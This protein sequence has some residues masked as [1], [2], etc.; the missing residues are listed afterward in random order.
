M[1]FAISLFVL[2]ATFAPVQQQPPSVRTST[3]GVLIDVTANPLVK[4]RG[5][6]EVCRGSN[7]TSVVECGA[8]ISGFAHG[9]EAV[10]RAAV[11][12]I[13]ADQVARGSIPPSDQSIDAAAAKARDELLEFCIDTTWTPGFVRGVV[14]QYAL[15]HPN[16]LDEPAAEI[17]PKVFA[18]AFPCSRKK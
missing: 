18:R 16:V 4:F 14:A 2:A 11:I 9:A 15:E 8:Y 13:V 7:S 3:T 5:V 12:Q 10:E 1:K 6:V 17:M